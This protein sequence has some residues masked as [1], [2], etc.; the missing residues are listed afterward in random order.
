MSEDSYIILKQY[1]YRVNLIFAGEALKKVNIAFKTNQE[2]NQLLVSKNDF[3]KAENTINGLE[4]DDCDVNA[5]SNGYIEGY[6]EWSKHSF[7]PLYW[8]GGSRIPYFYNVK[9]NFKYIGPIFLFFGLM[10]LIR[11][12]KNFDINNLDSSDIIEFLF[13]LAAIASGFSM[14]IKFTKK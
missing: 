4:L 3:T 12:V 7:N 2:E 10:G 11:I 5:G 1:K 14:L 9:N 6:E 8:L 13:I